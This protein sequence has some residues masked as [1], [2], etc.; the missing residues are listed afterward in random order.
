MKTLY[1]VWTSLIPFVSR[2]HVFNCIVYVHVPKEL[3]KKLDDKNKNYIFISYID[4][5][6]EWDWCVK[7][8]KSFDFF[9]IVV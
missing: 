8:N 6:G 2:L 4:G 3:R 7:E 5:Q 1:E 9:P